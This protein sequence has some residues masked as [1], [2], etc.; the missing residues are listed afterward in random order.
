MES[1]ACKVASLINYHETTIAIHSPAIHIHSKWQAAGG[2]PIDAYLCSAIYSLIFGLASIAS[3]S[4]TSDSGSVSY[5][6]QP[7]RLEQLNTK[8]V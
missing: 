3:C 4:F 8:P 7:F 5:N 2:I 6:D 1:T